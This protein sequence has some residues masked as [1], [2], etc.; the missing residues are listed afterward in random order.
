MYKK[1]I[2]IVL[3]VFI[4]WFCGIAPF[5][6][7]KSLD[8]YDSERIETLRKLQN[9]VVQSNQLDLFE[10]CKNLND[11]NYIALP[12]FIHTP[13]VDIKFFTKNKRLFYT[14]IRYEIVKGRDNWWCIVELEYG[15]RGKYFL[16]ISKDGDISKIEA[17]LLPEQKKS[18]YPPAMSTSDISG[19]YKS[20]IIHN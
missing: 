10:A 14:Y 2:A 1:T 7:R 20:L 12:Y 3:F 13:C 9:I 4:G 16:A 8:C 6:G 11:M 17:P 19:I 15:I 18:C 5:L